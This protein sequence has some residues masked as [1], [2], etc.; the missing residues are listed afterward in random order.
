[1]FYFELVLLQV[2]LYFTLLLSY[3]CGSLGAL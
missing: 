2:L 1:M 3:C